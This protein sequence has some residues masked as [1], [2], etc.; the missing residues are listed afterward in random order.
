M[1]T[2][3]VVVNKDFHKRLR[4]KKNKKLQ[5]YTSHLKAKRNNGT[6]RNECPK[7]LIFHRFCLDV[8]AT[9]ILLQAV[10]SVWLEYL[11][12]LHQTI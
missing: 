10:L 4:D 11:I 3:S 2:T 5:T 7:E 12:K 8:L 9:N 6:D 1:Y